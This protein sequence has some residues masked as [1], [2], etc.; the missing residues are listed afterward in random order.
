LLKGRWRK[1]YFCLGPF[2]FVLLNVDSIMLFL[3]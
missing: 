1:K 3:C 2:W